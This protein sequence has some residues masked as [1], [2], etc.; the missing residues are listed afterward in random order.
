MD[1]FLVKNIHSTA[2]LLTITLFTLRGVWMLGW[3]HLLNKR[4]VRVVPHVV[5]TILLASAIIMLFLISLNPLT[6]GWLL[7]KIMGLAAYIVLGTVA[8]KRGRTRL[9]R[10]GAFIGALTMF[11]YIYAV[12]FAR[13][14]W[15][16]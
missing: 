10:L 4:W 2:A 12:A 9:I 5:D 14:P 13:H 6:Q 11:F 3:P 15:P 16:L 8:L 7:A 1:Y